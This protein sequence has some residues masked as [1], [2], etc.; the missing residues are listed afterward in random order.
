M[1]CVFV[2]VNVVPGWQ[3]T[4]FGSPVG[5]A[6]HATGLRQE[7]HV[8]DGEVGEGGR[9]PPGRSEGCDFKTSK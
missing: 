5:L 1:S 9:G 3:V 7:D 4:R 2:T 8:H 6:S